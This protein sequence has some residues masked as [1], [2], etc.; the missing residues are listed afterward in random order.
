MGVKLAWL[1]ACFFCGKEWLSPEAELALNGIAAH[2]CRNHRYGEPTVTVR[3][4]TNGEAIARME[5]RNPNA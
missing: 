5:G 4:L 2:R 1:F 3:R